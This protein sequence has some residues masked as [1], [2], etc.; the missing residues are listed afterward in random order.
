MITSFTP[1]ELGEVSYTDNWTHNQGGLL[2]EIME[3]ETRKVFLCQEPV[4]REQYEAVELP[5]G[6]IKSGIGGAV[7]DVAYF[8]RSPG[9]KV[10]GPLEVFE[11][12]D[13]RFAYV[14]RPGKPESEYDEALVL[15]VYKYH[16]MFYAAGRTIEILSDD[17]GWDYIPQTRSGSDIGRRDADDSGGRVLPDGWTL[18]TV[19]LDTDLV[20]DVPYPARVLFFPDGASWQG[21]LRLELPS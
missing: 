1:A 21:P 6:F 8:R 5:E 12:G 4:T 15:P 19:V 13:L 11:I 10:A 17:D 2:M 9:A 14:A 16:S 18:R 3:A 20:V 7:A